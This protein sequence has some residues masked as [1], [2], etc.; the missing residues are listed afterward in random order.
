MKRPS[1]YIASTLAMLTAG[2]ALLGGMAVAVADSQPKT[3]HACVSN[4]TGAMRAVGST[5]CKS[6]EHSIS[7]NSKGL[8]GARGPQGPQGLQGVQ[9]PGGP[10]GVQGDMGPAGPQGIPGTAS[11]KGDK[12]DKGDTGPQGPAGP[13]GPQ[14]SSGISGYN[15]VSQYVYSTNVTVFCAQGQYVVGGGGST[16][17]YGYPMVIDAPIT[18]QVNGTTVAYGWTVTTNQTSGIYAYAICANVTL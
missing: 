12:G 13:A 4:K 14:G 7:W 17:Y 3:L 15:V 6:G 16:D 10:Q 1:R 8:T 2:G 9:G 5:S 11:G 18:K